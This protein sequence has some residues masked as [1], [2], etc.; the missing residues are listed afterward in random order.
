[1]TTPI[2]SFRDFWPFYLGQHSR[3]R[4]RQLHV[5]GTTLAVL[6]LAVGIQLDSAAWLLAAPVVGYGL[7]WFSHAFVEGNRPAT[8]QFPL[9]SFQADLLMC[10]LSYTGRLDAELRRHGIHEPRP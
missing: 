4:T 2:T 10:L 6:C 8:L 7:A 3:R 9:Y 5:M 1:M